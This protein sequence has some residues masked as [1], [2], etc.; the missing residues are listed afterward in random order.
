MKTLI[1]DT[2][3]TGHHSEYINH[4]AQYLKVNKTDEQFYFVVH[5]EFSN[6]FEEIIKVT[7]A[8]T[9]VHWVSITNDEYRNISGGGMMQTSLKEYF[10]LKKYATKLGAQKVY[11]LNFHA[12]KYGA[13]FFRPSFSLRSIM[14]IQFY[15]LPKESLKQKLRYYL[16]YQI[17]KLVARNS[18]VE[19]IFILNDKEAVDYMNLEFRTNVFSTLPD[20][21]PKIEA[22][23][24]FSIHKYYK[25]EKERNIFLHIGSLGRRKGTLEVIKSL[26]YIPESSWKDIAILLVG[27]VSNDEERSEITNQFKSWQTQSNVKLI[28]DESFVTNE[29]MRSIFLQSDVVLIP[30]KNV[31]FSSGILG[32]AASAGKPV[33]A[34]NG[35]LIRE[36][37]T[38]Y[39]LG[40]LLSVPD[41]KCIAEGMLSNPNVGFN[42]HLA[43]DFVKKHSTFNFCKTLFE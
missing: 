40:S 41:A 28:W 29:M 2:A 1:F 22:L 4:L 32:H 31:E 19:K 17:T 42:E 18:R 27:K 7:A 34:T 8:Q 12:I 35:G 26:N 14:F 9:N 15:R 5:P 25:I 30:Y 10:L 23:K 16:T 33:L 3:I 6:R 38:K 24:E 21:I 36:L 20:P 13:I 11:A 43:Q 37:V 39:E